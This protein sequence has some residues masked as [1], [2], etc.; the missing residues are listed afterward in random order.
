MALINCSECGNAVSDQAISC[1]SCG[2]PLRT[3][4][5]KFVTINQ[6]E[7]GRSS[8]SGEYDSLLKDGWQVV[9]TSEEDLYNDDG[10][11]YGV[12]YKYKFQ[13]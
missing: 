13:R 7:G 9:G 6:F 3:V 10:H 1:P 4:E 5:Y 2:Y 12:A 11:C 8:G